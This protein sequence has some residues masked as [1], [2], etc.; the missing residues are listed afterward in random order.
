MLDNK[1]RGRESG[2]TVQVQLVQVTYRHEQGVG[3]GALSGYWYH[4]TGTAFNLFRLDL[5]ISKTLRYNCDRTHA[6]KI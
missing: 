5:Y 3:R 1:G 4:G 2:L 6:L